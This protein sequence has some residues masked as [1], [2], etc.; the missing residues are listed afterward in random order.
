MKERSLYAEKN[1][2]VKGII[3]QLKFYQNKHDSFY[4]F[5]LKDKFH[6]EYIK[7]KFYLIRHDEKLNEKFDCREGQVIKISGNFY[8]REKGNNLGELLVQNKMKL[9]CQDNQNFQTIK[10]NY[11]LPSLKSNK[12]NANK[13]DI[14]VSGFVKK[15]RINLSSRKTTVSFQIV[16]Q[17]NKLYIKIKMLLAV[18]EEKPINN[19]HC[20]EGQFLTITG[21]F[22]Q[23]K[24]SK[25]NLGTMN[26]ITKEYIKCGDSSLQLTMKEKAQVKKQ[27]IRQDK[28]RLNIL[29]S[30]YKRYYKSKKN[31]FIQEDFNRVYKEMK[32][33]CK[34]GIKIPKISMKCVIISYYARTIEQRNQLS[35]RVQSARNNFADWNQLNSYIIPQKNS[36]LEII[37]AL[38]P[39]NSDYIIGIP[40]HCYPDQ[41]FNPSSS[42]FPYKKLAVSKYAKANFTAILNRFNDPALKC[43]NL[44]DSIFM[45]GNMDSDIG[46][47]VIKIKLNS[48]KLIKVIKSDI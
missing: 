29:F 2:E 8:A 48:T 3:T 30:K 11:N 16:E 27:K 5:N 28:Q 37:K 21:P 20:K 1:I 31:K 34:D 17:G 15:L 12:D 13:T 39:N 46:L 14:K 40:K 9:I 24:K 44:L 32:Q 22:V 19:F 10:T 36:I 47:E 25:T 38:Y 33:I 18:G 26:I 43:G 23:N 41:Q 35:F 7:L 45:I 42:N 6:K 4:K